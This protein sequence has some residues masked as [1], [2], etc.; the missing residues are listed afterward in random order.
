MNR[1][2]ILLKLS[3]RE[4]NQTIEEFYVLQQKRT[5]ALPK[6]LFTTAREVKSRKTMNVKINEELSSA[7]P[8]SCS[9][10]TSSSSLKKTATST[11]E[12]HGG[13]SSNRH[14]GATTNGHE[15]DKAKH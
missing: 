7:S 4:T 12:P 1:A 14:G 3:A 15:A 10:N 6:P 5:T 2:M 11:Q 13:E 9:K 8:R